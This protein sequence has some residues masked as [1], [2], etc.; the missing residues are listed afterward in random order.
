MTKLQQESSAYRI[1]DAAINRGKE[2]LRTIEDV[3]RMSFGNRLLTSQLKNLRHQLVHATNML[4]QKMLIGCRDAQTD[5]GRVSELKSEYERDSIRQVLRANFSR[6]Q[7]A[8]RTI[9]EVSKLLSV[10]VA[11]CAEQLRYETYTL[12]KATM[13]CIESVG[14]LDAI[15][16][17]V[18]L[19]CSAGVESL[20]SIATQLVAANVRL[21]QLRCKSL[22]DRQ[23]VVAGKAI[24]N[25]LQ[26]S[27][28]RWIMNDRVDLAIA[29]GADGVHLGQDDLCVGDARKIIGSEKLIGV[30]TH[31]IDQAKQ[32]ELDGAN[33]IGVGPIFESGTKSFTTFPGLEFARQV[34]NQISLP[35]FAIGGISLENIAQICETGIQRVAVQ[36]SVSLA[37]SPEQAANQLIQSMMTTHSNKPVERER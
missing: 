28:T 33:Y 4:D 27:A 6:V 35:A 31:D 30:S 37:K 23:I 25:L 15:R 36:G 19:D 11:K 16:V 2:G 22:S 14:S 24:T 5:V 7:Q 8:L 13:S 10:E 20:C 1:L 34:A 9:E 12:E 3:A 26:G 29:A 21:I 17:Y 32:A 18:L